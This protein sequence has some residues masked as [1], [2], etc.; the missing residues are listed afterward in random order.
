MTS[1]S[2]QA[3]PPRLM[4]LLYW[5]SAAGS[6]SRML[7]AERLSQLRSSLVVIEYLCW[8]LRTG[9]RSSATFGHF[10]CKAVLRGDDDLSE[11]FP[12]LD[13]AQTIDRPLERE[14]GMDD[15]L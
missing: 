15:G 5:I 8:R 2:C 4:D 13:H 11:D 6:R 12:V 10:L 1:L 7:Q 9:D 3:Y 14:R